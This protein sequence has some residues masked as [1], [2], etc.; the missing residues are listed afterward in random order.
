MDNL[1]VDNTL[2]DNQ[3]KIEVRYSNE[4]MEISKN[5]IDTD[6]LTKIIFHKDTIKNIKF[7][8]NIIEDIKNQKIYNYELL[9]DAKVIVYANDSTIK[10]IKG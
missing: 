7:N 6:G 4:Y 1:V 10:Y 2:E 5:R 9:G 8:K 3:I